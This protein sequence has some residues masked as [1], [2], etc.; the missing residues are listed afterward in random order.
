MIR[1][2]PRSTLFP[3]TTLFRSHF[4]RSSEKLKNLRPA[5]RIVLGGKQQC[6][7]SV[8]FRLVYRIGGIGFRNKTTGGGA[9]HIYLFRENDDFILANGFFPILALNNEEWVITRR[10][11]AH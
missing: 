1:R 10:P 5:L 7:S 8:L 11:L 3:Y 2:P 4:G 9:C 6:N